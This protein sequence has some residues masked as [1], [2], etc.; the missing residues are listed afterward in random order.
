MAF[1]WKVLYSQKEELS[2]QKLVYHISKYNS[3]CPGFSIPNGQIYYDGFLWVTEHFVH[4]FVTTCPH[5]FTICFNELLSLFSSTTVTSPWSI[6]LSHTLLKTLQ[7][8]STS[9]ANSFSGPGRLGVPGPPHPSLTAICTFLLLLL[10]LQ[11][12][13]LHLVGAIPNAWAPF[14]W[15]LLLILQC[16]ASKPLGSGLLKETSKTSPTSTHELFVS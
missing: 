13:W 15:V 16:S 5:S 3:I 2:P 1:R 8:F 12:H 9:N 4:H 14:P 6:R 10:G 7:K 11:P